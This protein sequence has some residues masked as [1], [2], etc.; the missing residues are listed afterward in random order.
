S[1]NFY[2]NKEGLGYPTA[3]ACLRIL[4]SVNLD[5]KDKNIVVLGQGTLVGRPV[6]HL[7]RSRG[8]NVLTIDSHTENISS[9]LKNADIIISGI[10]KGKFIKGDMVKEGVVIVDAGTSEENGS[11]IGDVDFESTLEIASYLT[12]SPG[13]VGPVT[14]AVLLENVL[15][16]AENKKII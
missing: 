1:N 2:N 3:I 6:T 13:G 5:L 16:V 10:G 14:V 7:L 11:V 12:P 8:F 4:D 9:L 15:K